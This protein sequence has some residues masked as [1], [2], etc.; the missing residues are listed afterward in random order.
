MSKE[1]PMPPGVDMTP[2]WAPQPTDAIQTDGKGENRPVPVEEL[3]F[4]NDASALHAVALALGLTDANLTMEPV[5]YITKDHLG[6]ETWLLRYNGNNKTEFVGQLVARME[7]YKARAIKDGQ[8]APHWGIIDGQLEVVTAA[9]RA[10]FPA[11]PYLNTGSG[12][13]MIQSHD[14]VK[15][16]LARI[17]ATLARIEDKL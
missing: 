15:D 14:D 7:N 13:G 1:Q 16:S 9:H 8:D 2:L 5:S 11:T 12:D 6:R 3:S 17:E 4:A 10:Q